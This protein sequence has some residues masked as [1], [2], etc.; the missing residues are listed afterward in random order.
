VA[1]ATVISSAVLIETFPY[2][3]TAVGLHESGLA[4]HRSLDDFDIGRQFRHKKIVTKPDVRLQRGKF[5][6]R[7]IAA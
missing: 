7:Y 2:R 1:S 5:E 4:E 3:L 6:I